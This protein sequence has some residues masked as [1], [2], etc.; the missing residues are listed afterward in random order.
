M[1]ASFFFLGLSLVLFIFAPESYSWVF[2]ILVTFCFLLQVM[3]FVVK[4]SRNNYINFYSLFFFSYFFVNFFYPVVLYPI[5]PE[6]FSIFKRSFNHN[7]IN[8]STALAWVAAS[9]LMLGASVV[10]PTRLLDGLHR[11]AT[12]NHS[13]V[14]I[15]AC[16]LFFI[17]VATVGR[18]FLS[19]NFNA[20]SSLSLYI[21][22]LVSSCFMLATVIIF[23]DFEYQ[24]FKLLYYVSIFG[25]LALFL[26]IGDRGPALSLIVVIFALYSHNVKNIGLVVLGP[27]AFLGM[28][29]MSVIGGGR[30][31]EVIQS[32]ENIIFRGLGDFE[33]S[34]DGYYNMT[35]DF[36]VNAWTLY[37]G[38]EYAQV[39]GLNWGS[40]FLKPL[41]GVIPFLQSLVESTFS[42][43]LPSSAVIFTTIGLGEG[44][45]WGLGTNLVA[46]VYISFGVFGCIVLFSCFGFIVEKARI[47]MIYKNTI[48]SN[49]LYF[50]LV[51]M[52]IYYPRTDLLTPLKSIFWTYIIYI[53]LRCFGV[54]KLKPAVLGG[55]GRG[56]WR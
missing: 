19:G 32:N 5:D 20:Q 54:L 33:F 12:M 46:S 25:F 43:K 44:A 3:P 55:L 9:C 42:L 47:N 17:F 52:A 36:V 4:K 41:L 15:L 1:V 24:K 16:V 53:L 30:S 2:N 22:P 26:S 39:N 10:R 13:A 34:I 23:R 56:A 7:V 50:A 18:D 28:L 6:Y 8:E 37:T 51:G 35:L 40:T 21:L 11:P 49:I 27:L 29:L 38:V 14:T 45:T 48:W 31:T